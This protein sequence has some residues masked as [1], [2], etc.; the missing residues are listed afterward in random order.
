MLE[1]RRLISKVKRGDKEALRRI[2][3]KYKDH[4]L[5][6]AASL[7]NDT[8]AAEDILHDVI[9]SFA[10]GIG[11]FE[12]KGSL[13]SYLATC[14]VNRVRDRFRRKMYQMIE[15]EAAGPISSNSVGPEQPVILS[16]ESQL[17]TDALAKLPF[18]QREAI[19]LHLNAG[20]KFREI[21][22]AQGVPIST[23]QGRYRYGLD[24][25]RSLMSP[26]VIR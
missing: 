3:E 14:V 23:A 5:T 18:E 9:V 22:A 21:A 26:E 8:P 10:K 11:R 20:L 17:L 13:R 25:L 7:L 1:D 12:L 4:L 15:L 19:I 6:I 24:K 16:E 2:Y